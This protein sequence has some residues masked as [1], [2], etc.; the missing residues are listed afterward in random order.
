MLYCVAGGTANE[1]GFLADISPDKVSRCMNNNYLTSA[2]PVQAALKLWI[3]DDRNFQE[4]PGLK[5]SPKTR[6]IVFVSS[7]AA[8]IGLPGYT[9]Y[10][11]KYY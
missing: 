9:A 2:F 11:R 8:F 5:Q 4:V 3:A 1:L 7:A 10:A 6:S